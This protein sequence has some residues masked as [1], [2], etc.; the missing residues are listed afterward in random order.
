MRLERALK[1]KLMDIRLRDKYVSSGKLSSKDLGSYLK[2]L[3]DDSG[4]IKVI[5]MDEKS[6]SSESNQSSQ[7]N[8]EI[9]SNN[10][11]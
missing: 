10:T 9:S 1:E 7:E 3:S 8:Q 4:N 5:D 6:K 11:N 2:D